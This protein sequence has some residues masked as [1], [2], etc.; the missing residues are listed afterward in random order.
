MKYTIQFYKNRR[1][2]NTFWTRQGKAVS[3][4]AA[5]KAKA[6]AERRFPDA[7]YRIKKVTEK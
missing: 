7:E 4:R 6:R 3:L 5:K 2:I 1:W